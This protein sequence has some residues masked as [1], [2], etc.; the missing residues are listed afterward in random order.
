MFL[1]LKAIK[2]EAVIMFLCEYCQVEVAT[3]NFR[4][5]AIMLGAKLT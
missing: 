5:V 1:A 3:L 4:A 2:N